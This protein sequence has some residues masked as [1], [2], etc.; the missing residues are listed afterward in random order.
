VADYFQTL[1]DIHARPDEADHLARHV[2]EFLAGKDV[3][4]ATPSEEGGYPRGSRALEI[5]DPDD[6]PAAHETIPPVYS[7]LQVIIGRATHAADMSEGRPPRATCPSCA[8]PLEDPDE[9]WPAAVQAWLAGDDDSSLACPACGA[10]APVAG[11]GYDSRFGFGTLA[12]RFW[13]WPPLSRGFLDELRRE[14]GHPIAIVR[15]KL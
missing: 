12:F 15:G 6:R 10:S 9:E 13:N 7:H 11:W 5:S 8:R 4:S 1:I 2:V 14:L 3:I